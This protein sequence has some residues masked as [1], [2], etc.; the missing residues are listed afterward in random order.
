[1][2]SLE[3]KKLNLETQ[4]LTLEDAI[5]NVHTL[6]A[7]KKS[8]NVMREMIKETDLDDVDQLM[9]DIND[10]TEQMCALGEIMSQPIGPV[11]DE[12]E[13]EA[14]LAELNELEA[15]ELL[16]PVPQVNKR[17]QQRI[18][19]VQPNVLDLPNVPNNK[20]H[21]EAEEEEENEIVQS[22]EKLLN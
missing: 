12:N 5:L 10:G 4:I 11:M 17:N 19:S 22:E 8:A 18:S 1:V 13:L 21:E 6:G 20:L 15:D 16:N 2:E 9:D 14:E 3:G 7:I